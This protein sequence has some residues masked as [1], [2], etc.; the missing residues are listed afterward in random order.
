[1]HLCCAFP[2]HKQCLMQMCQRSCIRA[3]DNVDKDAYNRVYNGLAG[4]C[5]VWEG[6]G[7]VR[8][9]F[10]FYWHSGQA[11]SSPEEDTLIPTT[12][13]ETRLAEQLA[14]LG[15]NQAELAR[16]SRTSLSLVARAGRGAQITAAGR[17][18]IMAAINARRGD[19]RHSMSIAMMGHF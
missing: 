1:M 17:A 6:A 16:R 9:A 15:W 5:A 3:R 10:C 13:H 7:K 19:Y 18:R 2:K 11:C 12:P 4:W 14:L 8:P